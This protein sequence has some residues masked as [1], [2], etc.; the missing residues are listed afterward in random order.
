MCF[1]IRAW[2][3][4]QIFK[5]EKLF[6]L[7]YSI[8]TVIIWMYV[9]I[10]PYNTVF[11][12]DHRVFNTTRKH[13]STKTKTKNYEDENATTQ[14]TLKSLIIEFS[15]SS[16]RIFVIVLSWVSSS[17]FRVFVFVRISVFLCAEISELKC[18]GPN[19]TPYCNKYMDVKID[20]ICA[21][22]TK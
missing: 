12:Y 17:C 10:L 18:D 8:V 6:R 11:R 4:M 9:R 16:F 13:E 5:T 15:S 21:N 14:N 22:D 2:G 7:F 1:S 19:G 3:D 20:K